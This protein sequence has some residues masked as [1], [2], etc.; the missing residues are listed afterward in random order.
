MSLTDIIKN[1]KTSFKLP[2]VKRITDAL[3]DV[4]TKAIIHFENVEQ[5]RLFMYQ[6]ASGNLQGFPGLT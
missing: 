1:W 2:L 5:R 6:N 4:R 3:A